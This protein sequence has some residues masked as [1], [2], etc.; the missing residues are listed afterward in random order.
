MV[1]VTEGSDTARCH[2]RGSCRVEACGHTKI[3]PDALLPQ[4]QNK[5]SLFMLVWFSKLFDTSDFAAKALQSSTLSVTYSTG[6][7]EILK[8]SF[9]TFRDNSG[10]VF[11]KVLM[12][13]EEIMIKHDIGNWD[14][15]ASRQRKLPVNLAL[16]KTSSI[17]SG[18]DLRK[19]GSDLR[20]FWNN[21]LERL[22]SCSDLYSGSFQ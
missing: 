21:I 6:L 11:D 15:S 22:L 7:I 19:S 13:T 17:K 1:V 18:S 20:K 2:F 3:E 8:S 10:G 16:G 4:V 14:V 9:S 12:L 5:T